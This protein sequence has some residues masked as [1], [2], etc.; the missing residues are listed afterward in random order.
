MTTQTPS[1]PLSPVPADTG[2][3]PDEEHVP[4]AAPPN[5]KPAP[6]AVRLFEYTKEVGGVALS[7]ATGAGAPPAFSLR[8]RYGNAHIVKPS[9]IKAARLYD[10]NLIGSD[11]EREQWALASFPEHTRLGKN[12]KPEWMLE[13]GDTYY[14]VSEAAASQSEEI[15]TVKFLDPITHGDI[16]ISASTRYQFDIFAA[17]HRCTATLRLSFISTAGET[18]DGPTRK[19]DRTAKG[20]LTAAEYDHVEMQFITPANARFLCVQFDKGQTEQKSTSYLFFAKPSL[21]DIRAAP[22]KDAI[23]LPRKLLEQA[24]SGN[25]L[26]VS[27]VR[28]QAPPELFED[29]IAKVDLCVEFD[30]NSATIPNIVLSNKSDLVIVKL[31]VDAS[32]IEFAGRF[33]GAIPDQ[34]MLGVFVDGE[35]SGPG[36]LEMNGQTFSGIASLSSKH[37]DGAAHLVELRRLPQ[38]LSLASVYEILPM[39]ITPWSAVQAYAG[40]PLDGTMAPAARH[41]LRSF[42][43]WFDKIQADPSVRVPPVYDELLGGFRKRNAYPQL[44]FAPVAAPTVSV[45]IPVHNKFEITYFCLCALLF[46]FNETTFEVIVVDDGSTDQTADIDNFVAGIRVVRHKTALGFVNSC[47][48][49]AAL[50][51]GEFVVM[52]NN[53]TEVTARWLDELVSTFRN[54]NNVGLAGSKLV[55]PDGHLQEAGGI[56]WNSGNPWNVGRNANA[57]DPSFNYLRQT[58]YVSGAAIML[59][60]ELWK[61]L[62]GFSA[63]FAPA[64]FEDTDLAMKVRAAGHCVVYVPTSTVFHFEGQSAGT[65][66]AS[67]MKRFQEV[68]RPKFKRKWVRAYGNHGTEGVRPDRE[69]DRNVALRVLF[70]DQHVAFV[71]NDAGSYAAFQEIRLFQSQGAKVTFLPRNLAWMD[72]HTLALQQIG[73]E[74]LYAP[75]VMDF[76]GYIQQHAAEY[77]VVYVTRYKIGEQ[78][79]PLIRSVAPKT[80]I[81]LNIADLHFLRELREAAAGNTNYSI[82]HAEATRAAELAAVRSS[83][84]TFSYSEIELAVLESHISSGAVTAKMPWIVETKSLS[85]SFESTKDILFLG[86]FGHPPNEQAVKFFVRDVLPLIHE[87]LPGIRF[88]VI[89]SGAPESIKALA[90]ESV[91]ILGYLPDLDEAFAAHR[92]FVAPLLAGAGLKGKVLEAMSRGVPSVLSPIAAEGTGLTSGNDC[93]VAKSAQEWADAVVKLYTDEKLWEQIGANALNLAQTRFSFATGVEMFQEALARIDIYGRKDWAL[94]YQHARPQRYGN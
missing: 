72:R 32:R 74:C 65:S 86:G 47:N 25:G 30:G 39:Q 4:S 12:L 26:A 42:R 58:D 62:G 2:E 57:A 46:A 43:A 60:T 20:G 6:R 48:D 5:A 88:N 93:L 91:H 92:V 13:Q 75:F 71:D 17:T 83:D 67:G 64:Y 28:L 34:L 45:I 24:R 18:I 38:M 1:D 85:R 37:L 79:I 80:K 16:P 23:T 8:D 15:A 14:V 76:A 27:Q 53:D 94:V 77:D 55:Y 82:E 9:E 22:A 51:R 70:V 52:L 78:V 73:V 36:V 10:I 50:A 68:N 59:P 11:Q 84:L 29:N 89:G 35:F 33:K 41:H 49:G 21:L 40:A 54:F 3:T 19:I 31:S 61:Q 69:K 66:V 63:E 87:R 90:S 44:S 81:V 7:F 56:V